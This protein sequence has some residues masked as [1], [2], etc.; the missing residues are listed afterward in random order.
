MSTIQDKINIINDVLNTQNEELIMN[1]IKDIH[2]VILTYYEMT[3]ET[4]KNYT[5]NLP[6]GYFHIDINDDVIDIFIEI[7]DANFVIYADNEYDTDN[8][9]IRM[10]LTHYVKTDDANN[11][12]IINNNSDVDVSY[13]CFYHNKP[14]LL[15]T[16]IMEPANNTNE[17]D[18]FKE[19]KCGLIM[20]EGDLL[21]IIKV[22]HEHSTTYPDFSSF[23]FNLVFNGALAYGREVC[24]QYALNNSTIDYNYQ[25]N[26]NYETEPQMFPFYDTIMY[27]IIGK[28]MICVQTVFD[29][30]MNQP[31]VIDNNNWTQYFNFAAVYG[32]LEI[33]LIRLLV[34]KDYVHYSRQD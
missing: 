33:I 11:L 12:Q 19:N 32:S 10:M 28:N 4:F 23:N 2:P 18:H 22:Y 30:F 13:C 29:M 31:N 34:I 1:T 26:Y 15:K 5:D 17:A 25:I 9:I 6:E 16:I 27:A 14:E 3:N 21:E 7:G 8:E 24:M 20:G